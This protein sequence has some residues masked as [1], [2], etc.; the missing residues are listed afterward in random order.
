MAHYP[1]V[2]PRSSPPSAAAPRRPP[3]S[4]STPAT[5]PAHRSTRCAPR[6]RPPRRAGARLPRLHRWRTVRRFADRR[7]DELLRT[8]VLGN[9]HS[10]NPTSRASTELVERR[11][12]RVLEFFNADPDGVR[13]GVHGQRERGAQARRRVVPVRRRAIATCSPTTTTTRSTASASS[14]AR[15]APRSTYLP[16]GEP[17]L[18]L[19]CAMVTGELKRV[20]RARPPLRVPRAVQLQRRA[21]PARVD[22]G[23]ARG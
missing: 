11:A 10:H 9:P 22:R 21:A 5:A 17:D 3:F 15:A 20:P 14:P 13:R 1:Q 8:G 2:P 19:D 16:V 6:V 18:R 23:G 7:H 12:K 4:P